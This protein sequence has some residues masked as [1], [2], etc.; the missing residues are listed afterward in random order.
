MPKFSHAYALLIGIGEC[1]YDDWSLPVTVKDVQSLHRILVDPNLCGYINDEKHVRLLHD[2][3]ATKQAILASLAWLRQQASADEEA[4]IIVYYSGHG[5][6]DPSGRYYLIPHDVKHNVAH[7]ALPAQEFNDALCQIEAQRLL[8]FLD[9]CHA[10][11]MATAKG[12]PAI[13]LPEGF[14]PA[15]LPKGLADDLQQG[16]GRMVFTSS[17]DEQRSWIRPDGTMSLYT[18]HLIEALQGAGNKPGDTVVRVSNLMNHLGQ[19]VPASAQ[20]LC[21]AKQDPFFSAATEDFPVAVLRGGKGLPVGGWAAVRQEAER[22]IQHIV[23]A[24]GDRS[25]A[26]GDNASGNVI[27]TGDHNVSQQGK[28]NVHI[29]E[30]QGLVIGDHAQVTQTWNQGPSP[31]QLRALF[32][33]ILRQV[34]ARAEDPNVDRDE[35]Q[36]TVEKVRDEALKGE[37]ASLAK[38]ER[39]LRFLVDMA[40]D[41][42]DVVVETLVNPLNGI[43]EVVRKVAAR[44]RG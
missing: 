23:Q 43:T 42:G 32:A 34:Q 26:L 5:W 29:N 37:Q 7:S 11:G 18:Y 28:Y 27:I 16:A 21:Q 31:E 39:W 4:T 10:E 12:R 8:V 20:Q 41:V 15:A 3:G 14:T 33:P 6:L 13:D 35:L 25:V 19:A 36:G 44:A 22:T 17:R 1:A 24:V 38:L 9:C 30:A 40:P 2:D